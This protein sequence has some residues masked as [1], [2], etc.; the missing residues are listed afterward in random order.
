[1]TEETRREFRSIFHDKF[2]GRGTGLAA[3]AWHRPGASGDH[4]NLHCSGKRLDLKILLPS[5]TGT[6]KRP[7]V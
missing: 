7:K 4:P 2:T 6:G 3:S 1:M 5:V